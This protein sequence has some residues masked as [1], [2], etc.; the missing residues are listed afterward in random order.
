MKEFNRLDYC[1]YLLSSQINY[2]KKE[3]TDINKKIKEIRLGDSKESKCN[4]EDVKLGPKAESPINSG[5]LSKSGKNAQ[6][7]YKKLNSYKKTIHQ[8]F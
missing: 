1:K 3:I 4:D 2:T 5:Q 7:I 6:Q 8:R